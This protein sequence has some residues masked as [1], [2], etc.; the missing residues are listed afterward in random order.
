MIRWRKGKVIRNGD[1]GNF[2]MGKNLDF[3]EFF[4]FTK[5]D[6]CSYG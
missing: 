1:F 6:F 4:L 5:D 3:G 2:Y